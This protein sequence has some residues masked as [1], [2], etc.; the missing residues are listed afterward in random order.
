MPITSKIESGL[1]L[2]AEEHYPVTSIV[3]G[4]VGVNVSRKPITGTTGLASQNNSRGGRGG[5]NIT[6]SN[7]RRKF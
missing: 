4:N 1:D 7:Y 5:I 2:Q 6:A 3:R